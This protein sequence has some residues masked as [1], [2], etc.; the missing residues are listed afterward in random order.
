MN[1][2][3]TRVG[4]YILKVYTPSKYFDDLKIKHDGIKTYYVDNYTI[5]Y[6]IYPAMNTSYSQRIYVNP[7]N[8]E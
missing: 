1:R 5:E 8:R 2:I 6:E 7:E 4:R 3:Q